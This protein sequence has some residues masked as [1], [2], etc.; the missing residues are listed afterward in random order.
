[1]SS[2]SALRRIVIAGGST[3]GLAVARTLRQEGF[4]GQLLVV[5]PELH[6]PY[7]R[8]TLSKDLMLGR[9]GV[10]DIALLEESALE[11]L[12]LQWYRGRRV[13]QLQ[14]DTRNVVLD[15]GSALAYDGLVLATGS[16][17]RRLPLESTPD[18]VHVLRGLDDALTIRQALRTT[19]RFVLVGGGF[20]GLELAAA[21]IAA[22][23][24]VTVVEADR[25]PLAQALGAEVGTAIARRHA[26]L[27]VEII[28]SS[29]AVEWVGAQRLVG[30][31]L[32]DGRCIAAD[33]AVVG[34][35]AIPNVG[36]LAGSPVLGL[37]QDGVSCDATLAT[38][39]PNVVAAGDIVRWPHPLAGRPVRIEHFE[40]AELSGA[41]AARRLLN[42]ESSGPYE[43]V[44][45]VWSHQGDHVI[46][47]AGFPAGG[48]RVNVVDGDLSAGPF[49][50]TYH[51]ADRFVG[52]VTLDSPRIFRR[53]RRE[54]SSEG[55]AV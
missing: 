32:D 1:M 12:D 43:P 14:A 25:A 40:H 4:D 44:P 34:I 50:V 22:G 28:V 5:E 37:G 39:L 36:W 55:V 15:D 17:P 6:P 8:T 29:R 10:A 7:D 20:V 33:L 11:D 16:S 52:V 24:E 13:A 48:L 45:F 31:R 26:E 38:A 2:R 30:V 35:G 21:A 23:A 47:A 46:H 41:H 27:G 18:G 9:S 42:H 51:D 53:L 54:L 3:A 19:R 49:A